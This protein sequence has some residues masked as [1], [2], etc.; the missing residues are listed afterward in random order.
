MPK[1][2]ALT[3]A[4]GDYEIVRPLLKGKVEVDGVDLTILTDMDSATR[5]WRFLND[6][7]FDVAELSGSSY[8]AARDNGLPFSAIPVFLHRRFRH[9]FMFINTSKGISKPADLKGRRIGVKTMMTTAVLWMRGILQSEYGVPLNSI[10]WVAEIEDDIKVTLPLEIRYSCLPHDKSVETMLAEGEL[11]AVFHS[12]LIKPFVAKDPRVARLFPDH[13]AEEMAYFKRSGIFPIM[14][15]LAIR[16]TLTDENPWLAVNLFK[17]FN[18]AKAAGMKRMINPRIV[19][20]AWYR[21]AWEEQERILGA[22]P[23]EY[24]LTDRNCKNLETLVGY[25]HEQGLIK[26]RPALSQL[27]LNVDQGRKRGVEFR[28]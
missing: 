23:W 18:E 13:K 1:K 16:K 25:S 21:D 4:C 10:E 14:H 27:F 26:K 8:L 17:A 11:D 3:L 19:P 22:D 24:G 15:V 20:L 12:D 28:I 6:G 5:H 2:L 9:G 7:E